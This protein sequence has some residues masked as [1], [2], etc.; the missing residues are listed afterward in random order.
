MSSCFSPSNCSLLCSEMPPR[1][2]R[3]TFEAV[4]ISPSRSRLAPPPPAVQPGRSTRSRSRSAQLQEEPAEEQQGQQETAGDDEAGSTEAEED[5]EASDDEEETMKLRLHSDARRRSGI[6]VRARQSR[7]KMMRRRTSW[8][9]TTRTAKDIKKRTT[10]LPPNLF[11]APLLARRTPRKVASR[12]S[13]RAHRRRRSGRGRESRSS[14]RKLRKRTRTTPTMEPLP[15][16]SSR[17]LP[18]PTAR[19]L[20]RRRL[21]QPFRQARSAIVPP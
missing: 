6:R 1:A 12:S 4:V 2:T 20:R 5:E 18:L 14:R 3:S 15:V 21:R 17:S 8:Q 13:S 10:P 9:R 7:S 16:P 19:P 11:P